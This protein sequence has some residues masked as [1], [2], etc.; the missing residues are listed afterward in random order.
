[1]EATCQEL[2]RIFASYGIPEELISD[3]GPQF[4]AKDFAGFCSANGIR[5]ILTPAYHAASNGAAERSVQV[6]KSSLRKMKGEKL[7]IALANVLMRYRMTPH[8]T[9][10]R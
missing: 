2:K 7:K 8:S 9:T 4:T 1:V 6:I 5:H 10:P 3:N